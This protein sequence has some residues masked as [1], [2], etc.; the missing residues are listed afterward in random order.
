MGIVPDVRA[1]YENIPLGTTGQRMKKWMAAA[2][3][4]RRRLALT[5]AVQR[6]PR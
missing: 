1:A 2:A 3:S 4:G 6:S 5:P